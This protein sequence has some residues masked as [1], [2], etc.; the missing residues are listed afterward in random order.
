MSLYKGDTTT[1]GAM[2]KRDKIKIQKV[3]EI[4]G[5]AGSY[6]QW[7]G[8][9]FHQTP[10]GNL[11]DRFEFL[12]EPLVANPDQLTE[13][14]GLYANSQLTKAQELMGEA[15]DH[16][17]GLQRDCY[18]LTMRQGMSLAEAGKILKLSK[19]DVQGYRTRAIAFVKGYCQRS[20]NVRKD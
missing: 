9:H 18:I 15:V 12:T 20:L 6:E 8:K 16:L 14:Q 17:Q 19:S 3:K 1:R 13:E 11:G 7:I 2:S 10:K 4:K 5:Y